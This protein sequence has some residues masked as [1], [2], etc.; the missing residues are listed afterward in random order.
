[1]FLQSKIHQFGGAA[2]VLG[3][4]LFL[5][6]KLNEMSRLFVGRQ[7]P[8]LISGRNPA[9]I[10]MG[11]VALIV[12]YIAFYQ[13]YAQRVGRSGK[14][15]LRLFSGGGILL[16]IG[17]VT[18]ISALIDFL[19]ATEA[20]FLFV[21]I[22]VLLSLIGLIWFGIL[23][24]RQ[25]VLG[26]WRWLPLLTGL[27]GFIGFVLF[28]G[29]EI[30]ATFLAFRTLFALGLVGLGLTLWLEAPVQLEIYV[31]ETSMPTSI[32]KSE[33]FAD[34]R[35]RIDQH[36]I[37]VTATFQ[38]LPR[39]TIQWKSK[40]TEW[41]IG[42]CFEHLSLTHEYYHRKID[43]TLANPQLSNPMTDRYSV[44]FWGRIYMYFAFNP[45]YSFPTPKSIT[46]HQLV[47]DTVLS[48]YLTKQDR[49]SN[50]LDQLHPID[51]CR[52]RVPIEKGVHFNLGDCLKVLVYHDDLHMNQAQQVLRQYYQDQKTTRP[53]I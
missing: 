49:L 1:M 41:N 15:A 16:A 32:A 31:R 51:L 42:Q 3:N 48:D 17:H 29:E 8:D 26:G 10:L 30:T 21:I 13:F 9:L 46:P 20:L 24:L 23:N 2:F 4:L 53:P 39:Q 33:L 28:S 19:P 44:S 25:S 11:Q 43:R 7:M 27:M 12:G 14:I 38:P 45:R 50:L 36:R 6:N 40:P 37:L 22:G 18:F 5:V 52:T 35:Q 34:L 47:T